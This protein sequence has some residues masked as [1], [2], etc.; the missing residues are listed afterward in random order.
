MGNWQPHR[1]HYTTQFSVIFW[2]AAL[3][4]GLLLLAPIDAIGQLFSSITILIAISL[5]SREANHT[6][7]H[8]HFFRTLA[9]VLALALSARYLLWRG[10]YTLKYSDIL[11]FIAVW[12]LFAAELYAGITSILGAI[13]NAFPLSRPLLTLEGIDK[14]TLPT[15]DVMIPSY[16]E[17]EDIL[18]VTIRAAKM[19]DYPKDKLFIHLLDDG[20]TD[21]KIN[22]EN[23]TAAKAAKQRRTDLQALCKRLQITYHTRE[24][25]EFAK[26]KQCK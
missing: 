24:K 6:Q 14:D 2:I 19:L 18:E 5:C 15:V 4:L 26:A 10:I 25:N 11:S 16:N 20:G 12:L 13:V 8:Q 21:Q 1:H 22:A 3:L 9:L 7:K 17:D 23:P